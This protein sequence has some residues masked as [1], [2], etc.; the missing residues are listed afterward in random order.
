MQKKTISH[1]LIY[2]FNAIFSISAVPKPIYYKLEE[3]H[4]NW[5][6]VMKSV[7]YEKEKKWFQLMIST[8]PAI[9]CICLNYVSIRLMPTTSPVD[10]TSI[11]LV[12]NSILSFLNFYNNNSQEKISSITF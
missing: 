5:F 11:Y 1:I 12:P 9:A 6:K 3:Y 2:L 10:S 7:D 8:R 4:K